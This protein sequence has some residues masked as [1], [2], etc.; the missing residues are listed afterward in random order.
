MK[1][2]ILSSV[3]KEKQRDCENLV[4]YGK[5]LPLENVIDRNKGY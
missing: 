4:R 3:I 5:G 1:V 2:I